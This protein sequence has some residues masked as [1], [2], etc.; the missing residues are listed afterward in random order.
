MMTPMAQ[1]STGRPY[2]CRPTTSG[3]ANTVSICWSVPGLGL[4][5]L[6]PLPGLDTSFLPYPEPLLEGCLPPCPCPTPCLPRYSGVPQGSLMRPFS[7]LA[8][9]KSLMTIFE[10]FSRL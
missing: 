1:Q 8:K 5:P 9:W 3:A 10:F 7:S 2:R 6:T 4:V